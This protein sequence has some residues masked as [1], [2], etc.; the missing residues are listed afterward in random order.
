VAGI[1]HS[2]AHAALP[3][4]DRQAYDI[5]MQL[6]PDGPY[7]RE[8]QAQDDDAQYMSPIRRLASLARWSAMSAP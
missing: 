1:A 6:L 8:L 3:S 7:R 4:R 5:F 2:G